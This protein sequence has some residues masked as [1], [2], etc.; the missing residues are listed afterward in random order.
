MCSSDL[1]GSEPFTQAV[2]GLGDGDIVT[3]TLTSAANN[4]TSEFSNCETVE[5]SLPDHQEPWSASASDTDNIADAT[6]D[7][8]LDCDDGVL[9]V[10]FVGK[11]PDSIQGNSAHWSGTIDTSLAEDGCEFKVAVMDQF[12]R[13]PIT[14]TGTETVNDGPNTVIAAI[15]SPREGATVL[16][17]GLI[18]LRGLILDAQGVL[19]GTQH[20]W[21]LTGPGMSRTGDQTFRDEQPPAGGWPL[22]SGN[23]A[24]YTAKLTNGSAEPSATDTVTFTVLRDADNDGIPKTVED[25]CLGGGDDDPTNADDDRD[26]DGIPNVDDPQP[27]VAA[28]SY[29]AIVEIN[30]DPLPIPSNGN[31]VTASVRVPGRNIAQVLASSV[32]IT[33]IADEDVS[34]NNDFRNIGWTIKSGVGT[35]KFDR[36]KL[37]TFLTQRNLLNRLV[38]ITVSGRSGAP[39]WTFEGSDTIFIQG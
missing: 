25:S 34:T 29:T 36:Q 26:S 18:P 31:P 11:K 6:L 35:A 13:P 4:N 32:R 38:T 12:N 37:I 14:T 3:A 24:T 39:P 1:G 21:T 28:S 16:Q 27:C 10:V 33:R 9:Q 23:S 15:S 30:P 8:Y 7:G 20:Q 2:S 17:Y 19:A 22:G 5:E